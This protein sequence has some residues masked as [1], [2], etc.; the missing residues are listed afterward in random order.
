MSRLRARLGFWD[1]AIASPSRAA[2]ESAAAVADKVLAEPAL[3]DCDHGRWTGRPMGEVEA[4]D[5]DAFANWL[6]DP[7]AAPHGG[8][9][10]AGV[11]VRLRSWLEGCGAA[12]GSRLVVA[13]P[14]I[15]RALVVAALD[16]PLPA[17]WRLDAAPFAVSRLAAQAGRWRLAAFNA[18]P[19]RIA[20]APFE[21]G[22]RQG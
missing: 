20:S 10:L 2:R 16:L 15:V 1:Q 11:V 3:R 7:H 18:K 22:S 12:P 19:E 4:D 6:T 9:S 17:F 13:P 8:E 14:F 21:A 5:R